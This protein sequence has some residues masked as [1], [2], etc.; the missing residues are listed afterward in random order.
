VILN[1]AVYIEGRS[2]LGHKG[3]M[4]FMPIMLELLQGK[5]VKPAKS[6]N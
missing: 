3:S 1:I 5:M 6:I 2:V 4:I